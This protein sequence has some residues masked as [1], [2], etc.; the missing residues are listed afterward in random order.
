MESKA[1]DKLKKETIAAVE[2]LYMYYKH[3]RGVGH[4]HLLLHGAQGFDKQFALLAHNM[5]YAEELKKQYNLKNAYLVSYLELDR[6]RAANL[7]LAIDNFVISSLL[8]NVMILDEDR[9]LQIEFLKKS[10]KYYSDDFEA[11]REYIEGKNKHTIPIPYRYSP[12]FVTRIAIKTIHQIKLDKEALQLE[13]HDIK[14]SF[15]YKA[16]AFFKKLKK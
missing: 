2:T 15:W 13:L 7:P 1:T 16:Y 12:G 5:K 11:L 14:E 9:L 10:L 6:L 8:E 3:T 4:T